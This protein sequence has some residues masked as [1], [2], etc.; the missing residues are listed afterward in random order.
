M[1]Y[2]KTAILGLTL[3]AASGATSVAN[4]GMLG[5]TESW[6]YFAYGGAYNSEQSYTVTGGNVGSFLDYFDI[7]VDDNSI[8]F[9]YSRHNGTT[10]WSP[11]GL[12]LAPTISNGIAI[13][14]L[15]GPAFQSVTIDG[16]TNLAGFNASRFS[17][18]GNQIQ[19]DWAD[20]TF[21]SR[22]IVKFDINTAPVPEPETYALMLA[23]LG[24]V[25]FAARRKSAKK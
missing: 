16:A 20:L 15:S 4:A 1:N 19:V 24:L 6:Q 8:T 22:T 12:S 10:T 13:N 7:I 3:A 14:M 2:L 5:S 18:T 9:D 21:D 17:F 11:S 23:G 25:G